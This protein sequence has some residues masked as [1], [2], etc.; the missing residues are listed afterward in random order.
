MIE[1]TPRGVSRLLNRVDLVHESA[2]HEVAIFFVY[3]YD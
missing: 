1:D 2:G 3:V